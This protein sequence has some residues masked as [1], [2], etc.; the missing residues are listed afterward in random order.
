MARKPGN[1]PT[2]EDSASSLA[3][4]L[5]EVLDKVDY[6][7]GRPIEYRESSAGGIVRINRDDGGRVYFRTPGQEASV[8][9]ESDRSKRLLS[10]DSRRK[11]ERFLERHPIVLSFI[12]RN[13]IR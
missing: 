9:V 6:R 1:T 3:E 7:G 8:R 11:L 2:T 12:E 10:H 13:R 4:V 5:L